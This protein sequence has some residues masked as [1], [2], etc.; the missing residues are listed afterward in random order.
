MAKREMAFVLKAVAMERSERGDL[1]EALNRVT[2]A[3]ILNIF[4]KDQ[5]NLEC[6][7]NRL[8]KV[9]LLLKIHKFA[10][11]AKLKE[12]AVVAKSAMDLARKLFGEKTLI[13]FKSMLKYATT[14][15]KCQESRA[16]GIKLFMSGLNLVKELKNVLN[17]SEIAYNMLHWMLLESPLIENGTNDVNLKEINELIEKEARSS[18]YSHNEMQKQSLLLIQK[19]FCFDPEKITDAPA[20]VAKLEAQVETIQA[21]GMKQSYM[22]IML[23]FFTCHFK[24]NLG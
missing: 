8:E 16:E 13:Y 19:A 21:A 10:D 1:Q 22:Q 4:K 20:F 6:L 24:M 5:E 7:V 3:E 17:D 23:K 18:K 9:D 11:E 15:S 2:R 14:L 12:I